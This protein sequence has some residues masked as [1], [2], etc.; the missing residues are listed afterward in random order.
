MAFAVVLAA[1]RR[2]G[3]P[4]FLATFLLLIAGN[5]AAETMR[6][7]VSPDTVPG[8]FWWRLATVFAALDPLAFYLFGLAT[9][10]EPR[11]RWPLYAVIGATALFT[12]LAPA[13]GVSEPYSRIYSFGLLAFTSAV[14]LAVFLRLVRG[15][16]IGP[17]VAQARILT[18]A[19]GVAVVWPLIQLPVATAV[20]VKHDVFGLAA[21]QP[22]HP[23][24][25][26]HAYADVASW[27]LVAAGLGMM[28]VPLARM[29]GGR[30]AVRVAALAL[31]LGYLTVMILNIASLVRIPNLGLDYEPAP[32]WMPGLWILGRAG[33]ALRWLLFGAFVST[34]I[35]RA[36]MLGLS[37]AARRSAARGLVALAI[38]GSLG[39]FYAGLTILFG[40]DTLTLRPFDWFML[41][42]VLLIAGQGF[43]PLI[44]R[45]GARLYGVPMPADRA[46][47]HATYRRAVQQVIAEGRNARHDQGIE[48]LRRELDIDDA[49]AATL[50]RVADEGLASP[51]VAGQRVG[52]RYLIQRLV[53]RGGAGRV[54]LAY[55]E[56]LHRDVVLKE[57][58][59]DAPDDEAALREA[60]MAGGLNH[61]NVVVVHDVLRRPGASLLVVEYVPGGSL[62]EHVTERGL[63]SPA[64]GIQVLDGVLAG[65]EAVHARGLVHRDLKPQNILMSLSGIPKISDFGIARAR[66]G[67]TARFD[68]PDA[69]V[70]TPEFMAP[71]QRAGARATASTDIYG[72]GRLARTCI[73]QPLPPALEQVI[74]RAV[75]DDPAD[76]FQSAS[77]MR[78]ALRRASAAVLS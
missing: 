40:T 68:E 12:L 23:L 29:R 34:A 47:A 6:A 10:P 25:L 21:P 11:R 71:E 42:F 30:E 38:V 56:I 33:V 5:Q 60:R 8:L 19:A 1:G 9:Q 49:E 7:L 74:G 70:G 41:A 46:A 24:D 37:L 64:E 62:A 63:L 18:Y 4:L 16:A 72:V 44:D 65:L 54:F 2:R 53:G 45:V 3:G 20:V 17:S 77:D 39:L 73:R 76:R 27:F 31:G 26:L 43:R 52:A 59:H 69:F 67:V 75:A 28:L 15:V 66:R 51:I 14:Y 55:D 22:G 57:V 32:A 35:L 13:I 50:E 36:D 58:L 78:E 61:P 48:R